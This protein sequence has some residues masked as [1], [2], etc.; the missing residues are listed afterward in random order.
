MLKIRKNAIFALK[1]KPFLKNAFWA[2]KTQKTR[3]QDVL[4]NFEKIAKNPKNSKKN[5]KSENRSKNR[6]TRRSR[7]Y[8]RTNFLLHEIDDNGHF[9]LKNDC[10]GWLVKNQDPLRRHVKISWVAAVTPPPGLKFLL[11]CLKKGQHLISL[12]ISSKPIQ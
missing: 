4:S 5:P 3:F 11:F 2:L 7:A 10:P 12:S 1:T 6:C 8:S 9:C